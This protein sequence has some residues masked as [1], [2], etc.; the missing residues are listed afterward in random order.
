MQKNNFWRMTGYLSRY[1]LLFAA[2]ILLA[3]AVNAADI[4]YP[5]INKR[6]IDGFHMDYRQADFIKLAFLYFAIAAVGSVSQYFQSLVLSVIGQNIM[7]DI[8]MQVVKK[9]EGMSFS[10]FDRHASGTILTR[11]TND[12]ESISEL[13]SGVVIT[14]LKDIL[15]LAS[16]TVSMFL[17]DVRMT[18]VS[19]LLVPIIV[20]IT[21][22]YN[23]KAK[24]NFNLIRYLVGKLNAFMAENIACMRIVKAFSA[25]PFQ[26]REFEKINT[27]CYNADL[28]AVKLNSF[29]K[30]A[31]ELVNSLGLF[32]LISIFAQPILEGSIAPGTLFAFISYTKSFF[33]PIG[34]LADKYAS[35]QAGLVASDR[36]FELLDNTADK[37]PQEGLPVGEAAKDADIEFRHVWFSYDNVSWVLKDVSFRIEHGKTAAFVGPT[38]SGKSTIVGIIGRFYMI[39]KGEVL[40]GG[41]SIYDYGLQELRSSIGFLMQDVF[42]FSGDIRSN[43]A[44]NNA[45]IAEERVVLAAKTAN[46]HGFISRLPN[47]Y[48][49][50]VAERGSTLSA[51]ERQLL[52]LSR[53]VA[54]DFPIILMD[55]ATSNIDTDTE[56]LIQASLER[57]TQGRTTIIVA[58]RLS[59]IKNADQ[60]FVIRKGEIAESGSH[61]ALMEKDGLYKKLYDLQSRS[62]APSTGRDAATQGRKK[63]RPLPSRPHIRPAKFAVKH[64]CRGSSPGGGPAGAP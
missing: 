14:M 62:Q 45:G 29:F 50:P 20:V 57:V 44:L 15:L 63:A 38:G 52:A 56:L 39:Q 19:L 31:A 43:I 23:K 9:I 18:A 40:F 8:R 30:P 24:E 12:I 4:V 60:I 10:F 13:Y 35:L 22:F 28:F 37:E 47:R 5:L 32:F 36:I 49:E 17:L 7:H 3:M 2:G 51:G 26:Q 27:Q 61:G 42:L 25:E 41:R 54:L 46:A 21:T 34:E 16:I 1:K 58:H 55:E 53:A 33:A 64:V 59:T 6:V 48:R 11:A